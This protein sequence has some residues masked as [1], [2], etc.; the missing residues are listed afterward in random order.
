MLAGVLGMAKREE[1]Q[2]EKQEEAQRIV[3]EEM[4]KLAAKGAYGRV[5]VHVTRGRVTLIR[6]VLDR[7]IA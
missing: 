4:E 7:R 1:T 6:T 3:K 5:E 2:R